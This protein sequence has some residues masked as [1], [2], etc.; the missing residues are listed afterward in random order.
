MI[1]LYTAATPN[2]H[3]I[4]IALEELGLPYRVIALDLGKLEQKEAA[5]LAIN[6]NGRIPAIIDH[7][8]GGFSVFESG[9]ILIYLAEKTGRLLPSD[10]KKHSQVLQW[11]MFQMGGIGPMMGQANVFYRYLPEKIPLAIA[12]YQNEGRRLF[13]V[14]NTQL[15]GRDYLVAEF[16]IADI[17]TWP[18]VRIY[19]WSGI[20]IEGLPHLAGWIQRMADRPAC[21]R[22]LLMPPSATIKVEEIQRMVS[23]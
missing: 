1:D 9:A 23:Q 15:N 10:T 4:S 12:R 6:P 2:G 8:N 11:L 20:S 14:L 5:F 18:W 17:A 3:K 13:E 22:G 16:S 19:E 7:D 21:Q